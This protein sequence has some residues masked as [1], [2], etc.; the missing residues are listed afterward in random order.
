[1]RSFIVLTVAF[2]TVLLINVALPHAL[3]RSRDHASMVPAPTQRMAELCR[4][5]IHPQ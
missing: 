5:K 4:E 2:V 3:A 1:M